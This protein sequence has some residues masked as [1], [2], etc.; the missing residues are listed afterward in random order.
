MYWKNGVFP[1]FHRLTQSLAKARYDAPAVGSEALL[2]E[3]RE[4]QRR[5]IMESFRRSR[6]SFLDARGSNQQLAMVLVFSGTFLRSSHYPTD[7]HDRG[8]IKSGFI[9]KK[10]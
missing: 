9:A 2:N 3:K 7:R 1:N 10:T 4:L 5:V 8:V 6:K